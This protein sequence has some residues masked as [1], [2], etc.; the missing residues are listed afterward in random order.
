[1]L[2]ML[3]Q[4]IATITDYFQNIAIFVPGLEN[5]KT[6]SKKW[7]VR[8]NV[9]I[10][11]YIQ[12]LHYSQLVS[13]RQILFWQSSDQIKIASFR[14]RARIWYVDF[15]HR[16]Q[17]LWKKL[18]IP[19]IFCRDSLSFGGLRLFNIRILSSVIFRPSFRMENP[20]N[21]IDGNA[22]LVFVAWQ[23]ILFTLSVLKIASSLLITSGQLLGALAKSSM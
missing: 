1:M 20:R 9:K 14:R 12:G 4:R 2:L 15:V 5:C 6:D 16:W 23:V 18:I 7:S 10:L 22:S 3:I 17:K 21:C 8:E 19:R 11:I 13:F